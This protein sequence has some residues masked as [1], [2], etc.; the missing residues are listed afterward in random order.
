MLYLFFF[1]SFTFSSPLSLLNQVQISYL[2][3]E[4]LSFMHAFMDTNNTNKTH[5]MHMYTYIY[6]HSTYKSIL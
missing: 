3:I 2:P 1:F 5:A 4:I 6:I